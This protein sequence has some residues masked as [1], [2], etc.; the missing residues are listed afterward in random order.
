MRLIVRDAPVEVEAT[1]NNE[2]MPEALRAPGN[3]KTTVRV[4]CTCTDPAGGKYS[5]SSDTT[6]ASAISVYKDDFVT[7]GVNGNIL[8][9]YEIANTHFEGKWAFSA[10]VVTDSSLT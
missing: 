10:D 3:E 6:T 9:L 8:N 4:I 7:L 2:K 5:R 1:L